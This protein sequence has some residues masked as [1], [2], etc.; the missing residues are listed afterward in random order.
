MVEEKEGG[1]KREE[2]ERGLGNEEGGTIYCPEDG[3]PASLKK[4]ENKAY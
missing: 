1:G 3:V 4:R 2:L